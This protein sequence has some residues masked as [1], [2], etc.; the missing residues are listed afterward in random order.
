MDQ[1]TTDRPFFTILMPT[2]NRSHLLRHAIR[3]ALAQTNTD[4]EIIV[5]DNDSS[6]D[7]PTVIKE[8]ND[9]KLRSIRTPKSLNMPDHWEWAIEHAHGEY[10][11]FLC[12]DDGISPVALATVAETI[13]QHQARVIMMGGAPYFGSN[14]IDEACRNGMMVPHFRGGVEIVESAESM[15]SMEQFIPQPLFLPRM[16]NSF[17]QRDFLAQIRR[18]AGRA[19]L[20][21]PDYSFALLSQ[22][23]S[24]TWAYIHEPLWLAGCFAESIGMSGSQ[25]RGPAAKT[26]YDEMGS[27]LFRNGLLTT[28][29]VTNVL[30]NT[31]IEC[32]KRL[33]EKLAGFQID[34]AGYFNSCWKDM[35]ILEGYGVDIREDIEAFDKLLA[36]QPDDIQKK[37]RSKIGAM[38][39]RIGRYF[40]YRIPRSRMLVRIGSRFM[41]KSRFYWGDRNR[42]ENIF[43]AAQML[44]KIGPR[45]QLVAA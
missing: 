14:S 25:N 38:G 20:F 32:K 42:F 6:D 23:L 22:A 27:E 30:A 28:F 37:V 7:T 8:F 43:E 44:P 45:K 24:P 15:Q 29:L 21:S 33:P 1:P 39:L 18:E 35:I 2:R 26:F 16:I 34:M 13:R 3:C 36:K 41:Y 40:G 10:I 17:V 31:Y 11:T 12:D 9:P 4:Y 5:S 19:F